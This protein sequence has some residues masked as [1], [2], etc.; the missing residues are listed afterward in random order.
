MFYPESRTDKHERLQVAITLARVA[1]SS[2]GKEFLELLNKEVAK[3]LGL[4]AIAE[5]ETVQAKQG[6]AQCLLEIIESLEKAR[7]TVSR[8]KE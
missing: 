6:R 7:E 5:M 4:L 3:T 2:E 8:L 1:K